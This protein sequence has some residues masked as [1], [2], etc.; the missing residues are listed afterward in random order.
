MSVLSVFLSGQ[1]LIEDSSSIR[2]SV[3]FSGFSFYLFFR[4]SGNTLQ[5]TLFL[6]GL[7]TII[8]RTKENT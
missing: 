3:A 2:S 7:R 1:V 8:G 6:C 5:S 4:A